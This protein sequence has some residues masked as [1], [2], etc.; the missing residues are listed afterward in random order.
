M[1]R[2]GDKSQED[3]PT[4]KSATAPTQREQALQEAIVQMP[5]QMK[6]M[7]PQLQE[8]KRGRALRTRESTEAQIMVGA[9][10]TTNP[11]GEPDAGNSGLRSTQFRTNTEPQSSNLP[12]ERV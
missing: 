3:S 10:A 11:P 9:G 2:K 6:E 5:E 4:G 8:G 7:V 12:L 1:E